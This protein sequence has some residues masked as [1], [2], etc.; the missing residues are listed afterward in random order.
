MPTPTVTAPSLKVH[1]KPDGYYKECERAGLL[2]DAQRGKA[3]GLARQTINAIQNGH[4]LP[5]NEFIAGVM[6]YLA[7]RLVRF[8]DVFTLRAVS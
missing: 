6:G 3:F 5:S 2:T 4:R 1:I 7:P 8:E